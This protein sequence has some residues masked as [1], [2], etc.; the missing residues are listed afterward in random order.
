MQDICKANGYK[1]YT[2][3]NKNELKDFIKRNGLKS[4]T[5]N[6]KNVKNNDTINPNYP[7]PFDLSKVYNRKVLNKQIRESKFAMLDKEDG[8][9]GLIGYSTD[10][11]GRTT[12]VEI[13]LENLQEYLTDPFGN[14]QSLLSIAD[15]L[16]VQNGLYKSILRHFKNMPEF[17]TAIIPDIIAF[18]QSKINVEQMH[19]DYVLVQQEIKKLNC[20]HEFKLGANIVIEK[21][22]Y[23]ALREDTNNGYTFTEL[24]FE[25]I[26]LKDKDDGCL[27]GAFDLSYLDDYYDEE[28]EKSETNEYA[29]FKAY[30]LIIKNAYKTWFNGGQEEKD[31]FFPLPPEDC[32][33]I[34]LDWQKLYPMPML[35]HLLE[36]ILYINDYKELDRENAEQNNAKGIGL[37]YPL[38]ENTQSIDM[39]RIND[40]SMQDMVQATADAME[41]AGLNAF[42]FAYPRDAKLIDFANNV[43][44]NNVA[45][46][47]EALY[48]DSGI[49]SSMFKSN[50]QWGVTYGM[51]NDMNLIFAIYLDFER[52]LNRRLKIL[53]YNKI[54]EQNYDYS[55]DV[56]ILKVT[57]YT[58]NKQAYI[59]ELMKQINLSM[60]NAMLNLF[61][62]NNITP[63]EN[64]G[65]GFLLKNVFNVFE[66]WQQMTTVNT[67]STSNT[68]SVASTDT[69]STSGA[70][71]N[72]SD[73]QS[74]K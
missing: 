34:P 26:V 39:Y 9:S 17:H 33:I 31:Q 57:A 44:T 4:Q 72:T 16:G 15:V 62:L 65:A 53:G 27:N 11:T 30:P 67:N 63:S 40:D 25:S 43:D 37:E 22:F 66:N 64:K 52:W 8:N 56:Q 3:L 68:G 5:A 74:T 38:V 12:S 20:Q 28:Y 46:A 18:D 13:T 51:Q 24:P 14:Y 32:I 2:Q 54:N 60:P 48:L 71:E 59:A 45:Q 50:T 7:Q 35:I 36:D 70:T 10:T 41:D 47:I 21:G 23:I 19:K 55:F 29:E 73:T 49:N 61:A 6:S 69:T 1:K 42:A 58:I